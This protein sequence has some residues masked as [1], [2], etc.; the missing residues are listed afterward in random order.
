MRRMA[1]ALCCLLVLLA[2]CSS[3]GGTSAGSADSSTAG[4]RELTVFA[5]SSLTAV[6]QDRIA[7][8][9]EDSHPGTTVT[10][11]VGASDSLAGQIQSEGTADVFAS[12]SGTWMDAVAK[13]PGVTSR[14]DFVRNRLVII[15]PPDNPA[16][17]AS[18]DDLATPGVQLVLAAEGVPVGD[19]AREALDHAGI[20]DQAE[21]NVVS[22]EEDNAS[23]VAKIVGG[24]ADVAIVYESDVSGA[25][26]NDVTAI[27]IPKD[28]NVIATYPIAVVNGAPYAEAATEFV[29]YVTGPEG[30]ASLEAYGFEPVTGGA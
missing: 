2:S 30:R 18:I 10:F 12:A 22:N 19:Y 17:I 25:A 24:E 1:I 9:F 21:G 14:T 16:A 13:D 5:A 28:V 26:G 27:S 8:D 15:T 4:W 23:V 20:L 7:P 6:F 29:D 11:N 3:D